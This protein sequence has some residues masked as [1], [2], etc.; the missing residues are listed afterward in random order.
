MLGLGLRLMFVL[1]LGL[2]LNVCARIR[3]EVNVWARMFGWLG[4]IALVSPVG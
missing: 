2:R 1:K 3:V 4:L